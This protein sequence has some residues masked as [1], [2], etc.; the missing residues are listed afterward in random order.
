MLGQCRRHIC[1]FVLLLCALPF[2]AGN[3]V[4]ASAA[5][6]DA[7]ADLALQ[8]LFREYPHAE[9][10]EKNA[11]GVLIFPNIVKGGLVI[12]GEFGEGVLRKGGSTAAYYNIASVSYGLQI[13]AQGYSQVLMFMTE[14]ALDFL[15]K[16][17]GFEIGADAS[18]A[19]VEKGVGGELSTNT[20]QSPIIGFV[21]G[22]SGLMG[23]IA[24]EGSKITKIDK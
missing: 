16:S 7:D 22:Q 11:A 15:D 5:A 14:D 13:G 24:I 23:G 21:F 4:A 2:A 6:I 1:G 12:G 10:L 18:V 17:E 19:L 3:A 20:A 9:E 8:N